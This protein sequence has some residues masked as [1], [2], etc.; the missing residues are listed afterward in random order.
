M[1]LKFDWVAKESFEIIMPELLSQNNI[2]YKTI[3]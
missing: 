1:I 3:Y 2:I